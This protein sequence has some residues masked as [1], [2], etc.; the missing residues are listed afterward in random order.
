[1]VYYQA[2]YLDANNQL[3]TM[4]ERGVS[5]EMSAVSELGVPVVSHPTG[6][7]RGR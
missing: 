1:V 7:P 4:G 2:R 3:V 6:R 5:A